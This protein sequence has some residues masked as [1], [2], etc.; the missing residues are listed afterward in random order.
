M[1]KIETIDNRDISAVYKAG[2]LNQ[3]IIRASVIRASM[4][5]IAKRNR[6]TFHTGSRTV[7]E[8]RVDPSDD[9]YNE[10]CDKY[11]QQ[12]KHAFKR[13]QKFNSYRAAVIIIHNY[14]IELLVADE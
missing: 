4:N 8:Y 14:A 12:F 13:M 7:K 1:C 5:Q 11:V 10:Q 2:D 9:D 3:L 6:D